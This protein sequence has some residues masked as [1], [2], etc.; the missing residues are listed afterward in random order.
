MIL[1]QWESNW[2][3]KESLLPNS[4][5][6]HRVTNTAENVIS[7]EIDLSFNFFECQIVKSINI[8]LLF[9]CFSP[10]F[11]WVICKKRHIILVR[12]QWSKHRQVPKVHRSIFT[13][14]GNVLIIFRFYRATNPYR[15]QN[16]VLPYR[17]QVE[18]WWRGLSV[19]L[20]IIFK[21]PPFL[22][23]PFR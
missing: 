18:G 14:L 19:S 9:S 17:Y 21:Q 22:R 3:H 23:L 11:S 15:Q 7:F 5:S 2:G 4:S 10:I 16:Q 8:T 20:Y 12:L 13:W 1:L 6:M